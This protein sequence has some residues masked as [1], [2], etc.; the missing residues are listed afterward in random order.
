MLFTSILLVALSAAGSEAAVSRRSPFLPL[1]ISGTSLVRRQVDPSDIPTECQSACTSPLN[2][3][4]SCVTAECGCTTSIASGLEDCINCVVDLD[5]TSDNIESGQET[6]DA[7]DEVCS[8][9]DIPVG[10]LTVTADPSDSSATGSVSFTDTFSD[11]FSDL[12]T[13]AAAASSTR[14]AGTITSS[15]S[16]A[17]SSADNEDP[18]ATS[19]GSSD[20]LGSNANGARVAGAANIAG[21]VGAG[22]LM[23][24]VACLV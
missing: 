19:T 20:P 16:A 21:V 13:S 18:S 7:Y 3:I 9:S 14:A 1:G 2:S 24:V 8:E 11:S 5:P 15:R 22:V 17:T 4:N 23:G 10:S 6:L 12:T